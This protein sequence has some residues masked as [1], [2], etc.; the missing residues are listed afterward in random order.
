M[1]D[2]CLHE[3]NKRNTNILQL[4]SFPIDPSPDIHSSLLTPVLASMLY[5]HI[6]LPHLGTETQE[7]ACE[8]PY[9]V[10]H[11]LSC[12]AYYSKS[13]GGKGE[14]RTDV[15]IWLAPL[16]ANI[17]RDRESQHWRLFRSRLLVEL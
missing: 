3:R 11:G 5:I 8:L 12:V 4:I 16:F 7:N 6:L 15:Q 1:T 14:G 13:G 17:Y 10:P 9:N 2:I